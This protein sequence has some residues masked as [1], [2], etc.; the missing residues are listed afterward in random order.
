MCDV[1]ATDKSLSIVEFKATD[2]S[3]AAMVIQLKHLI[4]ELVEQSIDGV[5]GDLILLAYVWCLH[6]SLMPVEIR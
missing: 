5:G 1:V 6:D 3:F 2:H 4:A